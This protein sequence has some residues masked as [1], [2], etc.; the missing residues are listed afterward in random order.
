MRAPCQYSTGFGSG[1]LRAGCPG[2]R[3]AGLLPA[4]ILAVLCRADKTDSIRRDV[5][6]LIG[7]LH[8][9]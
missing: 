3:G 5:P 6:M 8:H 1:R 7:S 4:A 2:H 9:S